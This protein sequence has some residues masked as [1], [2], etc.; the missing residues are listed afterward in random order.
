M[1]IGVARANT[2]S[3]KLFSFHI[4]SSTANQSLRNL[5][6]AAGYGGSGNVLATID[7]GVDLYATSTG[8]YGFSV[9]SFPAGVTVTLVLSSGSYISGCGGDA[10]VGGGSNYGYAGGGAAGGPAFNGF[11]NGFTFIFNNYGTLRGGGG[12]GGGGQGFSYSGCSGAG[13]GG[14]GGGGGQG[15][16]GGAGAGPGN[17]NGAQGG[18]GS[19][20]NGGGPGGGGYCNSSFAGPTG[21]PGYGSGGAGG[22]WG[23]AGSA[24]YDSS[25]LN[26][27]N[28]GCCVIDYFVATYGPGG[29]GAGGYAINNSGYFTLNNFGSILGPIS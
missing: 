21:G 1:P 29:G 11:V 27:W 24:G 22:T 16:I 3:N 14:G 26:N 23:T 28:I 10:G 18:P 5:A 7:S 20:G 25:N 4:T 9:G 19:N 6:G 15:T 2:T 13:G 8:L 17:T 12:G